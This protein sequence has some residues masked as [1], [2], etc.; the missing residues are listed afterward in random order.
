MPPLPSDGPW[1]AL[2]LG[3]A[4]GDPPLQFP[5]GVPSEHAPI[6]MGLIRD[7]LAAEGVARGWEDP[8]TLVTEQEL[9]Y[10]A[11][12]PE[13]EGPRGQ[14]FGYANSLPLPTSSV[15]EEDVTPPSTIAERLQ[16]L[17]ES[18]RETRQW[19]EAREASRDS[20]Q[21]QIEAAREGIRELAAARRGDQQQWG[22]ALMQVQVAQDA[23]RTTVELAMHQQA[24]GLR[25]EMQLLAQ[26]LQRGAGDS[27]LERERVEQSLEVAQGVTE[28]VRHVQELRAR[29]TEIASTQDQTGPVLASVG[30]QVAHLATTQAKLAQAVGSLDHWQPWM[31][32]L[33]AR[34]RQLELIP[35]E[36]SR[37]AE[38]LE[39]LRA[40]L[41]A[42]PEPPS[43]AELNEVIRGEVERI[44]EGIT[45]KVGGLLQGVAS[46]GRLER[47]EERVQ[48]LSQHLQEGEHS[49]S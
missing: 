23:T 7:S 40:Q 11:P 15:M 10:P 22:R 41:A 49:S 36:T 28:V 47:L 46:V 45:T 26:Q 1:P 17:D 27:V 16:K 35:Q 43:A 21:Q 6:D 12:K 20:L 8:E 30:A 29:T 2:P 4:I 48:Y 25:Q 13:P 3:S 33:D 14:A 34:V 37:L 32:D 44:I 19:M 5:V 18:I 24:E 42:H 38:L 9:P 39:D 31:V